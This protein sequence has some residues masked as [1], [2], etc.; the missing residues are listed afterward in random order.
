MADVYLPRSLAD[1]FPGSPRHLALA[2]GTVEELVRALEGQWPGMWD[3]LCTAGPAVREHINIFVDGE[4]ADLRTVLRPE[5][6]VRII[7]A[8]SGG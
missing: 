1:L 3:R 5:A 7:P 8:V 2:A 6:I 4:K